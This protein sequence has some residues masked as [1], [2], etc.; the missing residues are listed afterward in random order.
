MTGHLC[1]DCEHHVQGYSCE[2]LQE[3]GGKLEQVAATD[4]AINSAELVGGDIPDSVQHSAHALHCTA[5]HCWFGLVWFALVW[6]RIE[7]RSNWCLGV[8]VGVCN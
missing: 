2:I 3:R 8:L 1:L 4:G 5:L 6:M 7:L